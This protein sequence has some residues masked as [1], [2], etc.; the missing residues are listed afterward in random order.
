M[1]PLL[2]DRV[3]WPDD[4]QVDVDDPVLTD[5]SIET[6]MGRLKRSRLDRCLLTVS[7]SEPY[8]CDDGQMWC[9]KL[10]AMALPLG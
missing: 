7:L 1:G 6:K 3:V 8:P 5:P 2:R 4:S 9:S 10:I